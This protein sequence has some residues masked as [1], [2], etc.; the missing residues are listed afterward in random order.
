M[1]DRKNQPV[2]LSFKVIKQDLDASLRSIKLIRTEL[3][4]LQKAIKAQGA[5]FVNVGNDLKR[6]S[7]SAVSV[8]NDILK[9]TSA[10]REQTS[11]LERYRKALKEVNDEEDRGG[12]GGG[13]PG[14]PPAFSALSAGGG[15]KL[16]KVSSLSSSAGG[17]LSSV[18]LT[19]GANVARTLGQVAQTLQQ[20][21]SVGPAAVAGL[22]GTGAS[23][24]VIASVAA[25][26]VVALVALSLAIKKFT[27]DLEKQ[28]QALVSAVDQ[29]KTYYELVATGTTESIKL[30]LKELEV[31]RLVAQQTRAD[32]ER[33]IQEQNKQFGIL[34]GLVSEFTGLNEQAKE[35]DKE[36]EATTGQINAYTRALDSQGVA[37]NDARAKAEEYNQKHKDQADI[38]KRAGE[39]LNRIKEQQL[40]QEASISQRY[41]DQIVQIA[42]REAQAE[43]Q[44]FIRIQ[45]DA[46][47]SSIRAQEQVEDVRL[48][49]QRE[50]ARAA[51]DHQKNL[52]KIRKDAEN[53]EFELVLNRDFAGL[54][55]LRRETEQR[56][57]EEVQR[58]VEEREQRLQNLREE[59]Q[60][61]QRQ[62]VREREQRNRAYVQQITDLR[63]AKIRELEIAAAAAQRD[64]E[65]LQAQ[66]NAE[67]QLKVKAYT[68]ALALDAEYLRRRNEL[69]A[70][71]MGISTTHTGGGTGSSGSSTARSN[72][73]GGP[74]SA[75][76]ASTVNELS[77]Q[78]ESFTAGGNSIL[79]PGG[80]GVFIPAKSGRVNPGGAISQTIIIN[81]ATDIGKVR[82]EI[83]KANIELVEMIGGS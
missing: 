30:G 76:I 61:Q 65:R 77:G 42:E 9:G 14:G 45:R 28:K 12:R 38:V 20:I 18:G 33:V 74:L 16:S 44:A 24:A 3:S 56:L 46:A 50:E 49:F 2:E 15:S 23:L 68:E 70:K 54:A 25:L 69:L 21:Q 64:V 10:F 62:F 83:K 13:G 17:L 48:R 73:K 22:T 35:L 67:Y 78:R 32:L 57:D 27:E 11:D 26:V 34:G 6:F 29:Q 7:A 31:K 47:E 82:E 37:L 40:Q 8:R 59:L 43:Q 81:G 39:E 5:G 63:T 80:M 60:D 19:E 1:A 79:L 41:A 36:I 52:L 75:G 51:K 72:A 53:Q 66:L 4:E 55:R 71:S 58:N